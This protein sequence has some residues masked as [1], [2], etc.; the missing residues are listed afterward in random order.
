MAI[1]RQDGDLIDISN[2]IKAGF[3]PERAIAASI[4]ED[5]SGKMYRPFHPIYL[6]SKQPPPP[7]MSQ[8]QPRQLA[9]AM[10]KLF[11]MDPT[12]QDTERDSQRDRRR[13]AGRAL[14]Q[15]RRGFVYVGVDGNMVDTDSVNLVGDGIQNLKPTN[16]AQSTKITRFLRERAQFGLTDPKRKT[17]CGDSFYQHTAE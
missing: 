13:N 5:V 14:P 12:G 15:W 10:Q 8:P 11:S 2:M 6:H 1:I 4:G 3:S 16:E 17:A 9:E 7:P